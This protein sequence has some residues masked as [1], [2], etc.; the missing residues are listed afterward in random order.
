MM[1]WHQT[2]DKPTS[3]VMV[4][5]LTHIYVIR[6]QW[7]NVEVCP[8]ILLGCAGVHWMKITDFVLNHYDDVIKG[9]IASQITSLASVYSVVYSGA[10]QRKHQSS[11]SLA[12]VQGIHRS[13]R[14][15]NAEN[16][17]IWWRHHVFWE[18][19]CQHNELEWL[20]S[21]TVSLYKPMVGFVSY[22]CSTWNCHWSLEKGP[23]TRYVKLRVAHAPGMRGTFSPP[24]TSKETAISACIT[25]RASRTCRDACRDRLPAVAVKTFPSFPAHAQTAILRVW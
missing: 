1:A 4:G 25:E 6:P 11:A 19:K 22:Q 18:V 2:N 15:S 23:L 21:V 3:E 9:S 8:Q 7:V 13:R 12:F 10:D 20:D 14:A 5:F 17:S 16:A 24:L